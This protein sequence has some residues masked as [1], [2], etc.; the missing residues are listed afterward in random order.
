MIRARFLGVIDAT[1]WV[2]K[3]K[4][5]D[6]IAVVPN[7]SSKQYPWADLST[8]REV[9]YEE[10]LEILPEKEFDPNDYL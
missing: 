3:H 4:V 2:S 7:N 8:P 6:I 1:D 5:G 10:E 9:F